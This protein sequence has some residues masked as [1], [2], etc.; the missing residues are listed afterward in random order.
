[1][2]A[3]FRKVD[4]HSIPVAD[5]DAA[6]AFYRDGLGHELIWRDDSAAGLRLPDSDAELVLHTEK[7]PIE[8]DLL[9][10]SVPAAISRFVEAGGKV[11]AGPFEIRIGLCAVIEDPW[12]NRLVILDSSK[13]YLRT[14]AQRNVIESGAA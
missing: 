13:G 1:M 8:T 4:C 3:L 10:A 11:V 5:L 14:D 6:L 7:R 2:T 12:H 9:V